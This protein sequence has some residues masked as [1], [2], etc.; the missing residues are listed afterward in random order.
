MAARN[1][2]SPGETGAPTRIRSRAGPSAECT[3]SKPQHSREPR[4][5]SRECPPEF[6]S[7]WRSMTSQCERIWI[8]ARSVTRVCEGATALKA[9]SAGSYKPAAAKSFKALLNCRV[10]SCRFVGDA[11]VITQRSTAPARERTIF[12]SNDS[13]FQRAVSH[14]R[15]SLN[16]NVH[17]CGRS[18]LLMSQSRNRAS[19]TDHRS[20]PRRQAATS[21]PVKDE[22]GARTRNRLYRMARPLQS[23]SIAPANPS[24]LRG[25]SEP[26]TPAA[27]LLLAA[28]AVARV[29]STPIHTRWSSRDARLG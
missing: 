4:S 16:S 28:G 29:Y 11:T 19:E 8:N 3:G 12:A 15:E 17:K 14:S 18:P 24:E 2:G 10:P 20:C 27:P 6:R 21:A 22:L 1:I 25:T 26:L 5:R 13:R 9:R 23:S 7:R